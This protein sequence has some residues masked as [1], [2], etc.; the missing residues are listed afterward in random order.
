MQDNR[1]YRDDLMFG[2]IVNTIAIILGSTVG[3]FIKG[4]LKDRYKDIVMDAIPLAVLFIGASGA[5]GNMLKPNSNPVLFIISLVIGALLG[6]FIDIDKGFNKLGQYL[7]NKFG[8]D[9]SSNIAQGFIAA[10]LLFCVGSMSILG[11]LESGLQS[12]HKILLAKSVLDGVTATIMATTLGIGVTISAAIV[13]LYQGSIT[14]M[15]VYIQ[16]YL[17]D[18]MIREM[19]IVGGILIFALGINMMNI[20]PKKIKVANLLPA[21]LIPII[22][23]LQPVQNLIYSIFN[24]KR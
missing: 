20:T 19:S 15:A 10:S 13:F 24:F 5:I 21:L 1:E 2:T 16:P 4:G 6:E 17:T 23:Y 22:F 8:K 14:V 18:D 9:E 3:I 12:V 7:Q 11:S